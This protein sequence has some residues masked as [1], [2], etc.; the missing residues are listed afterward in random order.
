MSETEVFSFSKPYTGDI[1]AYVEDQLKFIRDT[2]KTGEKVVIP[3]SGGIDSRVTVVL[4][5]KA[6][7]AEQVFPVHLNTNYMRIIDGVEEI[8]LVAKSFKDVPNFRVLDVREEFSTATFHIADAAEKRKMFRGTYN[9]IIKKF[10]DEL[11][12]STVSDGTIGP[13]K[14]ETVGGE[15]KGV[16]MG[17][18]KDQHNVGYEPFERKIEP[19]AGV[20]KD[21]VRM[22][23]RALEIPEDLLWRQPFP[24]PG[25]S[26]RTVGAIDE[27]KLNTEKRANDIVEQKTEKFFEGK[28]GRPFLYDSIT[29]ER[30]PFQY[31]AA[32]YDSNIDDS[33]P[34]GEEITEYVNRILFKD[35]TETHILKAK[36]T[37][38]KVKGDKFERAYEPVA[39]INI[40]GDVDS[41]VLRHIG[42]TIPLEF[43][44]SR[45]LQEIVT[46]KEGKYVVAIRAVKSRNALT[47]E[48]LMF[49]YSLT[50]SEIS[51]DPNVKT[52]YRDIT[53]KPPATIENE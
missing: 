22:I 39:S 30:M 20:S 38:M 51:R 16:K 52:V 45:V 48:P 9:D 47:A 4:F 8:E 18:I 49:G 46:S 41:F 26:L 35:S 50:A 19:L 32:T 29:G 21:E 5:Q 10:V 44:V 17:K 3:A 28:Y 53:P 1:N 25:L 33:T 36:S 37:A 13:D 7:P 14:V 42:E 23:G 43:P 24:G 27:E 12:I 34:L 31:F 11:G 40:K 15:Y 2:T 6:L